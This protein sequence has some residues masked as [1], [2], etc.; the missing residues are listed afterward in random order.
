MN[1][2]YTESSSD[3]GRQGLQAIAQMNAMMRA[4][5]QVILACQKHSQIARDAVN[6]GIPTVYIPFRNNLY[7]PSIISLRRLIVTFRPDIVIC[8]S[9]YDNNITGIVKAFLFGQIRHFRIIRQ[10]N[11]CPRK[12][13]MFSLN[14]MSD[15]IVVPS[16]KIRSRLIHERCKQLVVVIP[17]GVDFSVLRQQAD[18]ALPTHI[19]VWL[20]CR[21]S[22]PVIVQAAMIY[23]EKGV[24]FMLN[25]L[26]CLRQKGLSFYWLI[27]GSGSRE[28]EN[29][30]KEEIKNLNMED[31]VLMCGALTPVAPLY[32]IAS[33]LVMPSECEAFDPTIVEATACGVPVMASSTGGITEIIQ[34][35]RTGTLI[36]QNDKMAWINALENFLIAPEFAQKVA[37]CANEDIKLRHNIDGSARKLIE[38]GKYYR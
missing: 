34:N 37:I 1:I 17:P 36:S 24:H 9:D 12:I 19:N 15:V 23:P 11:N 28:H 5:H 8:H 35:G 2:I 25:V 16:W 20:N 22:A 38:L 21:E 30:L 3:T 7:L 29:L 32:R 18:M 6:H 33:L 13:K 14:Y 26:H 27:A 31:C 4:G 10:K